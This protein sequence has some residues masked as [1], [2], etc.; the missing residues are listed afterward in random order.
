MRTLEERAIEAAGWRRKDREDSEAEMKRAEDAVGAEHFKKV[1]GEDNSMPA[2][3]YVDM[4]YAGRKKYWLLMGKC[5]KCG[6]P[7]FSG[8]IND[9]ADLGDQLID[10]T[11][12]TGHVC[13]TEVR[14]NAEQIVE[15]LR[16]I[17]N[18]I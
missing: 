9:L 8:H 12:L 11:P 6:R 15:H 10:F 3:E 2:L 1:F 5:P 14:S 17:L 16:K 7:T 4:D 18:L 13:D